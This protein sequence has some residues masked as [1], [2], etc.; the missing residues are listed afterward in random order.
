[1]MGKNAHLQDLSNSGWR[2]TD[3]KF[4]FVWFD[5]DQMSKDTVQNMAVLQSNHQQR[6]NRVMST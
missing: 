6:M 5:E 3:G 4:Q 2:L 1:M